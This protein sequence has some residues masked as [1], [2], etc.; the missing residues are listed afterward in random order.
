MVKVKVKPVLD[1][2][3]RHHSR[4][5]FV[6]FSQNPSI[7]VRQER[8][9]CSFCIVFAI[10]SLMINNSGKNLKQKC[11]MFMASLSDI[12]TSFKEEIFFI[13]LI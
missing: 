1:C 12:K 5:I 11:K 3:L 4:H 9:F 10:L 2:A 13:L 7:V 8:F 6:F